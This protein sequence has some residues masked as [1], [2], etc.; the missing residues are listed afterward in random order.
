[1][2]IMPRKR[3]RLLTL[4]IWTTNGMASLLRL[5][6]YCILITIVLLV[7]SLFAK[8]LYIFWPL[9]RHAIGGF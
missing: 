9:I 4:I 6:V 2:K 1:M 8:V 5:L 3:P 7:V